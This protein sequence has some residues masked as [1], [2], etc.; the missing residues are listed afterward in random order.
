MAIGSLLAP[1]L[2]SLGGAD[3]ALIGVGAILQLRRT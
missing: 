2:V 3:G 1:A